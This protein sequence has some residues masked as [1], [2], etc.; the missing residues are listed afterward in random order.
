MR[1]G[2]SSDQFAA[3]PRFGGEDPAFATLPRHAERSTLHEHGDPG[4]YQAVCKG[5]GWLGVERR[6]TLAQRGFALT[7]AS[8]PPLRTSDAQLR[9]NICAK[10]DNLETVSFYDALGRRIGIDDSGTQTWTVFN[11]RVADANPY[12][13]F[14]SSGELQMRYLDGPAVDEILARTDSSGNIGWYFTDHLGSVIESTVPPARISTTSSTTRS[15]ISSPRP[16]RRMAIDSCSR[17][18]S[19]TRRL[20][21]TTITRDIMMQPLGGS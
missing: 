2:E 6:V 1:S 14:N 8:A 7:I 15:A 5:T 17:G 4:S 13:D 3:R 12:A 11:G 21:F 16:T 19:M 10:I 18:C 20:G 9:S